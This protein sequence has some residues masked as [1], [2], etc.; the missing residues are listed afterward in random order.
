VVINRN[1]KK[2]MPMTILGDESLKK[3]LKDGSIVKASIYSN[4]TEIEPGDIAVYMF[5]TKNSF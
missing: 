5:P 4:T 1:L 3:I 2:S